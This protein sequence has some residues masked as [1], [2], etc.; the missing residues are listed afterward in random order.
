MPSVGDAQPEE[1]F[2]RLKLVQ[3]APTN[4]VLGLEG[5]VVTLQDLFVYDIQG[6]D[7]NGR[8]VGRHRT[9][10]IARPH[11][12]EKAR[13]FGEDQRLTEVLSSAEVHDEHGHPLGENLAQT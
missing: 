3:K 8:L 7:A 5:Q 2:A 4:K 11:F 10:G 6:E 13:Y 1:G 9:T 12:Y